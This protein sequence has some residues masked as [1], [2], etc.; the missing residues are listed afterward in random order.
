MKTE[1]SEV[2]V[3][4]NASA[5]GRYAGTKMFSRHGSFRRQIILTFVVGFFL[6][7]V[8]F[9]AYIV[10][11]ESDYLYHDSH[12]ETTNLAQSLAAGSRS[13][14]LANDV[15][16]LQ[17]VVNSFRSH[18]ELRYAMV[19]SP[20]G[21]LLAH[22]DASKMGQFVSDAG[23]LA[24]I[25][26]PP[27][28]RVML[29]DES[30]ID[31]AVPIVVEGRHVGW[32]RVAQGRE[33]IA[34]DLRKVILRSALFIFISTALSLLAAVFIA[35]RL[36]YRIGSLIKVA[37]EVQAGNFN[38]RASVTGGEEEIAKLGNS[39]NQMLDALARNK[40]ELRAA[41]LYTRSLIDASLD[42]LVTISPQGKITDV[43]E[44]TERVTGRKRTELI[45]T[46]F[47]GYFTEPDKA[48]EGY[49][50]VFQEGFVTDYPLTI[51][52]QD[53][54]ITDVLYNAS[55]YRDEV[56]EVLGVF[57][58]ARDITERKQAEEAL[59]NSEKRYRLLVESAPMCIH[60]IGLDGRISSMNRAGLTMMGVAEECKIQGF[61]YLD[62]VCDADRERIGDLLAKAYAGEAS[63]FEFKASGPGESMFKSCFVPIKNQDGSVIKLMGITEDITERKRAEDEIKELNR[64]LERRVVERTAQLEAEIRQRAS[65]QAALQESET[66]FRAITT[67]NPDHLMMQ[68]SGLRYTFVMNPQLGLTVQDMLGK[69]DYDFLTHD[70]AERLAALK[71][72][73]LA[74]GVA[75][76]IETSLVAKDGQLE[77]FDG[78]YIPKQNA[79]GKTDGL[80]GY[81]RNVTERKHNE[82]QIQHLNHELQQRAHEL[83]AAN[84]EL[85]SFSYS[86]SH[87]L[88][89]PLRAIDG[90]SHILLDD[91]ADKLD[92]EGKRLLHV[93]R[94]NTGK[95]EQL[96]D[97]ILKFSRTSRTEMVFSEIDM[98][99]LAHE[100][101]EGLLGV[102]GG[103]GL[104]VEIGHI[105]PA[106]GDRAML[107]QVF[108]NLLSNAIKFSRANAAPMIKVGCSSAGNEA[109]YFVQDNGAGFDMKYA[110]RLFGV[111]QR[112]HTESEF[113]GTGI[114]LAIVKRVITR[115]GGRVWAEGKPNAGATIYF[116][117]PTKEPEHE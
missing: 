10:Q 29:D 12:D 27:K 1:H 109:V 63:Y 105:P 55:V 36:G 68:D 18:P 86:V 89:T 83:E 32:A 24:L 82:E 20:S 54:H 26:A 58:A 112:L 9:V 30:I 65:A 78:A 108:V 37:E 16:G 62:A 84:K 95:L 99:G 21:R 15:V 75:E 23:S 104:K 33:D 98:E 61:L 79:E 34:S 25:K 111:F 69:T 51:R 17:E 43:N 39:L 93:V 97:D 70:D 47:S 91:Y 22:S 13:W 35:N 102:A 52:H 44:M 94:D 76:H 40:N 41:S 92:D 48:R 59:R 42:P 117:L 66:R 96:I 19:I 64:N 101:Y 6:L 7:I 49:H 88:R 72:Q 14:V 71:R 81:F 60:E 3:K 73:I 11:T 50:Q 46:D 116:A 5:S 113:E 85:E 2:S 74:T 8:A 56:G 80:I 110:D 38:T 77:Y 45:G 114:G 4:A 31:I 103:H 106:Q 100:V 115:H 107:R 90:F 57:A 87:D 53:G 28:N 67:H